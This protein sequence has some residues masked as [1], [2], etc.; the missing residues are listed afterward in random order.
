MLE[1]ESRTIGRLVI[2]PKFY[3]RMQKSKICIVEIP[4][5]ERVENIFNGYVANHLE[6]DKNILLVKERFLANLDKI[7]KRL[8]A[9]SHSIIKEKDSDIVFLNN[10]NDQEPGDGY[11]NVL[12]DMS[13]INYY[14]K[15]TGFDPAQLMESLIFHKGWMP[16]VR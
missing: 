16:L 15:H 3:E 13:I 10:Q 14:K 9:S 7:M 8:G 6:N 5:E 12:K 2:P 4:I 1:D 11:I